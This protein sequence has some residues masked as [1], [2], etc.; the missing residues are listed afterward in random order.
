MSLVVIEDLVKSFGEVRALDGVGFEIPEGSILG[1]LGPNGSGKT[2]TVSILSTLQR[3]TAGRARIAGYDVVADAAQVREIISLTGQYASLDAKLTARENISMFGRLTGLSRPDVTARIGVV[4]RDFGLDEFIDRK[5]ADLSGGMRRRVDIACA[6]ITRP[7][8]LF[9]DEPTT[10]LD[11]RS[12]AAVWDTIAAL[13]NDGITVLLTTQYLE[14]A[15]R[16]ADSIV[17]LDH[18]RIVAHGTPEQLKHRAGSAVC[19]V[20]LL[21]AADLTRTRAALAGFDELDV[22][23]GEQ[24]PN[25]S[26]AAPDELGTVAGVVEELRRNEIPVFDIGLRRPSLDE[27]F[28]ALTG[29]RPVDETPSGAAELAG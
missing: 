12:R 23:A 24:R 15:D 8:V 2:T 5:V 26:I 13:R 29:E 25:L 11:P 16:L 21:D 22:A 6:L 10:G 28:F 17:M 27:V 20:T 3:P 4:A 1:L 7:R 19:E 14:E 18:G 9:L